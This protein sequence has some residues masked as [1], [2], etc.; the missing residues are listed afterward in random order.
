MRP[1]LAVIGA[2]MLVTA[3]AT[4]PTF[5]TPPQLGQ[6][7]QTTKSI[8]LIPLKAD[9]YQVT[10]GG[11]QE[12]IDEWSRQARENVVA[13]IRDEIEAKPL[14]FLKAFPETLMSDATRA[15]L[16]ETS[17]LFDAVSTSI[18]A[19][20]YGPADQRFQEK[21]TNFDYTVGPEVSALAPDSDAILF[22]R[23]F[24]QVSTAGR[25]A[26]QAGS[27]ILGALV[28]VYMNPNAGVTAVNVAL[29][30]AETGEILWYNFHA[31][32]GDHDLRNPTNTYSLVKD[33]LKDFPLK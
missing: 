6:K 1:V 10:A 19:H 8:V 16:E 26:L 28:G 7:I 11:I 13:A 31:S 23:C 22:V 4:P 33:L 18:I 20:V 5:R 12:K 14:L 9:V 21:V 15:N 24:D 27:M 2:A 29:V 30:D 17:A 25:K 3:C 32:G